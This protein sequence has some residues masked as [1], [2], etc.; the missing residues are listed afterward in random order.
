[1]RS[2]STVLA[3]AA[4]SALALGTTGTTAIA[5]DSTGNSPA[6]HYIVVLDDGALS[7]TVAAAH[8]DRF[9]FELGHVYTSA[10]DG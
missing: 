8:A 6:G 1:M 2:R 4:A 9:G 10:L 3:A 7:R 5:A